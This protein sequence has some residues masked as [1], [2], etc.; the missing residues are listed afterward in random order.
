[1]TKIDVKSAKTDPETKKNTFQV[2]TPPCGGSGGE[3]PPENPLGDLPEPPGTFPGSL[4]DP[5][6]NLNF[7]DPYFA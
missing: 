7:L 6:K 1:M 2:F 4:P 5:L 3:A